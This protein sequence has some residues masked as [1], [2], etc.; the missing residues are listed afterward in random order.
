MPRFF[1]AT[2]PEGDT[3]CLTGEDARHIARSL[4][5]RAGEAL[6]LCDGQGTDYTAQ[7]LTV[8]EEVSVKIL[9][10]CPTV[11][12]PPAEITL[13]QAVPKGDK[14]EWIIQKSV[15]LGVT[16]IVPVLTDRCVARPTAEAA[17]KKQ[18]RYQRIAKEAAGQS[19]RGIIPEIGT[20]CSFAEA[21]T[22][23]KGTLSLF[24]YEKGGVPLSGELLRGAQKIS[25]FI[26]SEGGFTEAEAAA[27]ID[28]GCH[29]I[30]L[31]SRIL[32]CETAPL[33]ALSILQF[34]LG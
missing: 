11:S 2:P 10:A 14:A 20:Q 18:V 7:I 25:L 22:E 16:R 30:T 26:G 5:M 8:G 23:A 12:E 27:A 32:R 19:G 15:E 28:A 9:S 13:Y 6:T 21:L 33:C 17:A 3:A 1:L 29:T 24:C 31:G 34:L 4:R